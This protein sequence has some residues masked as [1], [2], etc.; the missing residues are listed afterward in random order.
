MADVH[1]DKVGNKGDVWKHFILSSVAHQLLSRH[2]VSGPS[3]SAPFVYVD[4]HCSLGRFSLPEKGQWQEGIGLFYCRKWRLANRPYFVIEQT[5]FT[6][7]RSYFGSWSIVQSLLR[8]HNVEGDLRLHDTSNSVS[9]Q[10]AGVKGYCQSDGFE[11]VLSMP[12]ANLYLVDPA[13]SDHRESDWKNVGMVGTKFLQQGATAIIWYPIFIKERPLDH[14]HGAVLAEIRWS[15]SGA[16]QVMRGCG[17]IAFGDASAIL[18][19]IQGDLA[20]VAMAFGGT[21]CVRD[22]GR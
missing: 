7:C 10:L 9:Q 11:A 2:A 5:A 3:V 22:I 8:S 12:S 19:E 21:S 16:N 15:V 18:R 14:L 13:Y 4:S 1:N 20:E 6:A 17:V